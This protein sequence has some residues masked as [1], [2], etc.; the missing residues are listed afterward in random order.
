MS[1]I[2]TVVEGDVTVLVKK[3]TKKELNDSQ[4]VDNKVWRESL[5]NK[6]ILRQKLNDYLTEQGV[7]SDEKQKQYED[8][9]KKIN[10]REL[11]LKKG[12]I[13]LKKAK[14]IALELKRFRADFRDLISER[15]SYDSNTA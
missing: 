12:G 10:E 3:P 1:D 7:W 14:S 13:P 4:L 11:I 2:R 9:I 15:T 6:A 5:E 8:Y